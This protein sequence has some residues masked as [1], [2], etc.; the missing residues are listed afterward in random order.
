[1]TDP[2]DYR[3]VVDYHT[4]G[5]F[6]AIIRSSMNSRV[7]GVWS[8]KEIDP[9]QF[10]SWGSLRGSPRRTLIEYSGGVPVIRDI[11]PPPS[12]E[13]QPVPPSMQRNTIDTLSASAL[14]MRRV[15]DTG[16]CEGPATTFDG[17][18]LARVTVTT[19][20]EEMLTASHGSSFSGPALRCDF[21]GQQLAGFKLDDD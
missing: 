7:N 12:V 16:R 8:E 9:L 2:R 5:L 14:L 11:Q 13:R 6:G 4:T 21:V 18:R 19:A 20:G 3:L 10:Y 1:A 17:Q 15:A